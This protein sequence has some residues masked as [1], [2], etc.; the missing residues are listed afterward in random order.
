MVV[1]LGDGGIG[2]GG[3][4]IETAARFKLP[5]C[6]VVDNNSRWMSYLWDNFFRHWGHGS[7]AMQQ[8]LRYDTM[9]EQV[10]CHSEFVTEEAQIR[11]AME[12]ALGSGKTSIV[13]IIRHTDVC[14]PWVAGAGSLIPGAD[15][16]KA[17]P[18]ESIQLAFPGIT[19]DAYESVEQILRERVRYAL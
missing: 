15:S 2:V 18:D 11:P 12:R 14:N 6:F 8:D 19:E 9:F 1:L 16:F 10:G 5:I 4:D 3:M 7:W 17:L 13:N